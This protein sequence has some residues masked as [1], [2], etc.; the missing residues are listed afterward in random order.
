MLDPHWVYNAY[1]SKWCLLNISEMTGECYK[2]W[3]HLWV[4]DPCGTTQ[5]TPTWWEFAQFELGQIYGQGNNSQFCDRLAEEAVI[6]RKLVDYVLCCI[7]NSA[8]W[9]CWE[10]YG[11]VVLFLCECFHSGKSAWVCP[12]VFIAVWIIVLVRFYIFGAQCLT[13]ALPV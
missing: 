2:Q 6:V 11:N 5:E 4:Q 13:A 9:M 1:P 7:S 12:T 3:R 10:W 8:V